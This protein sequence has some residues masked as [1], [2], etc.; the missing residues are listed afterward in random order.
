MTHFLESRTI[1]IELLVTKAAIQNITY[2]PVV[3]PLNG[4]LFLTNHQLGHI[5]Q[6]S[7]LE[8]LTGIAE[9]VFFLQ[10]RWLYSVQSMTGGHHLEF[11]T[12]HSQMKHFTNKNAFYGQ[13]LDIIPF[14][15]VKNV[16]KLSLTS[17]N[18]TALRSAFLMTLNM[19]YY[20][21]TLLN[22]VIIVVVVVVNHATGYASQHIWCLSQ[23]KIKWEGCCRKGSRYKNGGMME[24]GHWLVR[25]EW[26]PS[27]WSMCLLLLSSLAP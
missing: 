22:S 14:C 10:T 20:W 19:E 23:C 8:K 24:M 27:W 21:I 13:Q 4:L 12:C 25:M 2:Q 17:Y 3:R 7:P 26:H 6:Q 5:P 1:I 15:T 18:K 9:V 16:H 11:R